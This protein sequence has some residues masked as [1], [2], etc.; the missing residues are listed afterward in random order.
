M[1]KFFKTLITLNKSNE[2]VSEAIA[3]SKMKRQE[4][5]KYLAQYEALSKSGNWDAAND[6]LE[7]A[8]TAIDAAWQSSLTTFAAIEEIV[9]DD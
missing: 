7:K 3:A 2:A 8:S 9:D 1:S 4:A 6:R 5:E